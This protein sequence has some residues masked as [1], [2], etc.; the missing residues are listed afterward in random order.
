M[1]EFERSRFEFREVQSR[2]I[3]TARAW[4][5]TARLKFPEYHCFVFTTAG[6]CSTVVRKGYRCNTICMPVQR[7]QYRS[8]PRIPDEH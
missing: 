3:V 1:T 2:R 5:C 7:L 6:K 8:R 4:H